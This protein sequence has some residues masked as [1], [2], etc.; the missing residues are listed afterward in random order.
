[1][2]TLYQFTPAFGLPNASPFCMKLETFLR[3]SDL[4]YRTETVIDMRKAPKGK[5]PF[6]DIDGTIIADSS[7]IIDFIETKYCIDLDAS[8]TAIDQARSHAIRKMLEENF[9]WT[10]VYSRWIDDRYWP[11]MRQAFFG[12]L[13]PVVRSIVSSVVRRKVRQDMQRQGIGRHSAD[14]IYNIG[15]K[16]LAAVVELLGDNSYIMGDKA[17]KTDATLYGFIANVLYSPIESPLKE[18]ASKHKSLEQ[19]CKRMHTQYFTV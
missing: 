3:M 13:P 16:D 2:I 17:T 19:Y 7:L 12:F 14:E 11:Q 15:R 6:A 4:D 8:L 18:F 1:M 5:L 10:L 9:Y